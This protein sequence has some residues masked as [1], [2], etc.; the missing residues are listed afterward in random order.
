MAGNEYW[1]IHSKG[2][3]LQKDLLRLKNH[4]GVRKKYE[5]SLSRKKNE[6]K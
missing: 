2:E 1:K 4:K 6:K 3:C 5:N